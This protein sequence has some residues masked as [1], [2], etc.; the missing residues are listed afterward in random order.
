[1]KQ[2]WEKVNLGSIAEF[3]NGLNYSKKEFGSGLKVINVRDFKDRMYPDYASVREIN[4]TGS[5][6]DAD[7]LQNGDILFVR[8]MPIRLPQVAVFGTI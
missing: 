3:R 6:R 1:M 7:Y 4:Y 2:D 8:S 5:I